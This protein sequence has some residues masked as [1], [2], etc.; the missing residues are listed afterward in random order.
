MEE[1]HFDSLVLVFTIS[2]VAWMLLHA[3]IAG[4][5]EVPHTR[6]STDFEASKSIWYIIIFDGIIMSSCM[7]LT[8]IIIILIVHM[9][10]YFLCIT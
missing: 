1:H 9:H 5:D 8:S 7:Q 6:D 4:V 2:C 3:L 10:A